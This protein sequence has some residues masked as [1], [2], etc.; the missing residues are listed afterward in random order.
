MADAA[1]T[2]ERKPQFT[3]DG[4]RHATINGHRFHLRLAE[5]DHLL[6][7]D[8]RQPPLILD[9]TAAQFVSLLIDAMWRFQQ[10]AGDQSEEVIRFVVSH[11]RR[12]YGGLLQ[13]GRVSERR[14]KA[15][16]NRI[17]AT[18]MAVAGGGCPVEAG[19]P[20]KIIE[21]EEW[22]APARMDLAVTYRCN[23]AC[24]KCYLPEAQALPELPTEAW[25]GIYGTLWSLGV[26]QVVFTGGEP[27]LREDIVEL[28]SQADEFVTGLVTNGVE[29]AQLAKPLRDASLDYAQVTIES[30]DP[31][32]HDYM[33]GANGAAE[34]TGTAGRVGAHARTVEGIV[35]ARR[36]GLQVVTNT[37]LSRINAPTFVETVRWLAETLG[38]TSIAC[39]TVI[40]S[41][42]GTRFRDEHGLSD[43]ELRPLLDAACA[44]AAKHGAMLQ[45]YSPTCYHQGIDPVAMGLGA[46]SCSAATHNM[47]IQPDGS[48]LPCQS[49]PET[50]GNILTDD[51]EAIWEHPVSTEL[52]YHVLADEV[53]EDCGDFEVCGGGCPLD[54]SPRSPRPGADS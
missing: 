28:V 37:T 20:A 17:F 26:P 53:C 18:L 22:G 51:W 19:L 13:W 42:H 11:V 33:T 16:L 32:V 29:L 31:V 2:H 36:A 54:K 46:K 34:E 24:A 9:S 8:G 27:T 40:C 41:G 38:I 12:R 3:V 44:E 15:D 25:I 43:R 35:A 6:W 45:W 52:R 23:L 14:I 48:V 5:P 7:I 49:W 39:N 47:T 1:Q 21:Y 50:V 30:V 10:G 4:L